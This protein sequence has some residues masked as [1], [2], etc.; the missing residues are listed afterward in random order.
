VQELFFHDNS[1]T[2][3]QSSKTVHARNK[4]ALSV[5]EKEFFSYYKQ[6]AYIDLEHARQE[7]GYE[8][9]DN[10]LEK[11]HETKNTREGSALE[12]G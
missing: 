7:I 4:G 11:R 8:P 9:Q 1:Q 12:E 5:T 6:L 10:S 2:L 3:G